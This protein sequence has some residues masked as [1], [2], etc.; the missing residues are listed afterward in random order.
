LKFNHQRSNSSLAESHFF[1]ESQS[2]MLSFEGL[3]KLLLFQSSIS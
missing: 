3:W 1:M 2:N